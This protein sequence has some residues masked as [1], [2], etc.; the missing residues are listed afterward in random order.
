MP[1]TKNAEWYAKGGIVFTTL[2][3]VFCA[4][5]IVDCLFTSRILSLGIDSIAPANLRSAPESFKLALAAESYDF[6]I[7]KMTKTKAWAALQH[8]VS[9]YTERIELL[10][11]QDRQR[12]YGVMF[13][14]LA[15]AIG[16]A[17]FSGLCRRHKQKEEKESRMADGLE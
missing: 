6:P 1:A 8:T 17:A 10:E 15:A 7:D 4:L 16:M 5:F 12:S 2:F 13:L 3:Y 9:E 11:G 14:Y